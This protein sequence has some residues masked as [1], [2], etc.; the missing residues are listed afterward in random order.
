[1]I[2]R[3]DADGGVSCIESGAYEGWL[4]ASDVA[5]LEWGPRIPDPPPI[6]DPCTASHEL[7]GDVDHCNKPRGHEEPCFFP[8]HTPELRRRFSRKPEGT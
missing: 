3:I 5:A 8:R 1:M 2:H 7:N 4:D 6:E